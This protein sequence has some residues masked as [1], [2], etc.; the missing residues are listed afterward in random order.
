MRGDEEDAGRL[1]SRTVIHKDASAPS[2]KSPLTLTTEKLDDDE[3]EEEEEE[4]RLIE[5][6]QKA[7]S[8]N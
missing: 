4:V 8:G 5:P 1:P 6:I 2:T 3:E 7:K